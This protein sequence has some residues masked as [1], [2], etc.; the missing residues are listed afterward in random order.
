MPFKITQNP[1]HH[2]DQFVVD[3]NWSEGK[4]YISCI[5]IYSKFD[6]L[7]Q[8]KTKDWRDWRNATMPIFNRLGKPKLIKAD[9]D[10]AYL[11]T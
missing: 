9:R 4:H 5:D 7:E 1:E 8:I 10:G 2:R 3:I 11:L 6:T